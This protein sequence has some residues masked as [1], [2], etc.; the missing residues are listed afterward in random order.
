MSSIVDASIFLSNCDLANC[1]VLISTFEPV[2]GMI[3]K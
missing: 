3:N 1:G 2:E